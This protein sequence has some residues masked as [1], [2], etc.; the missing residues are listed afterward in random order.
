MNIVTSY[1]RDIRANEAIALA[2][3]KHVTKG[4]EGNTCQEN[5]KEVLDKDVGGVLGTHASSLQ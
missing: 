3:C 5:V 1:L 4:P 2:V